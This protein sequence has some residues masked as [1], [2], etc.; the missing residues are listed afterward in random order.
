[1]RTALALLLSAALLTCAAPRAG[2]GH[3][4]IWALH[5][6]KFFERSHVDLKIEDGRLVASQPID[7]PPAE[8]FLGEDACVHMLSRGRSAVFCPEPSLGPNAFSGIQGSYSTELRDGGKILRVILDGQFADLQLGADAP[9]DELRKH[10]QLLGAIVHT[11][12]LP[13]ATDG[14][15]VGYRP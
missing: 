1:M 14:V 15:Y 3:F 11:G 9:S 4:D 2:L 12:A 13:R 5:P 6:E 7:G 10:P 8:V